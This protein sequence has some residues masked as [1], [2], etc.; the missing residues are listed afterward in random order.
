MRD[1]C[2]S[3]IGRYLVGDYHG[4]LLGVGSAAAEAVK[5]SMKYMSQDN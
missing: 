1:E 5:S 4:M 2:V 3:Q